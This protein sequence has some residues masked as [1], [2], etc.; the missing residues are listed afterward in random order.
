MFLVTISCK[1][2]IA[3]QGQVELVANASIQSFPSLD[4]LSC[5]DNSPPLSY[6][7]NHLSLLLLLLLR[8]SRPSPAALKPGWKQPTHHYCPVSKHLNH[9][10]SASG[11]D[12]AVNHR[13]HKRDCPFI[14]RNASVELPR[15][16]LPSPR[17]AIHP[18]WLAPRLWSAPPDSSLCNLQPAPQAVYINECH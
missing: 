8:L 14:H 6:T 7:I 5:W 1:Q 12:C 16:P 10:Q 9:H 18:S 3:H 17:T 4:P 2:Q 11:R 13:K 15:F